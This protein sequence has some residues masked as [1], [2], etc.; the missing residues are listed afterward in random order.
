M[1][2]NTLLSAIPAVS[3]WIDA[4]IAKYATSKIRLSDAEFPRLP[5]YFSPQLL[6]SAYYV[7][8]AKIESPPLRDFGL[9]KLSF[10]EGGNYGGI[11]YKDTYFATNKNES[12]HFHE[13]IHVIQW[14]ELG[15]EKFLHAYGVGLVQH[16]Y[17]Q[18]PLEEIAYSLQA[19]F[20]ARMPIENL[21]AVVRSHCREVIQNIG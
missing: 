8:V 2:I 5:N 18:S 12:L 7:L 14:N 17:R 20:D 15:A 1:D 4:Y 6:E 9:G 13:L 21:E 11:T 19:Q 16:G 10:F 3:S